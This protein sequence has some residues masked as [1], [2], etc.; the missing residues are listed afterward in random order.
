MEV[1]KTKGTRLFGG[2]VFLLSIVFLMVA[3]Q[4]ASGQV[5]RQKSYNNTF[6]KE[7]VSRYPDYGIE[8]KH[9]NENIYLSF[10]SDSIDNRAISPAIYAYMPKDINMKGVDLIIHFDGGI[11]A[12]F[13]QK[14]HDSENYVEFSVNQETYPILKNNAFKYIEFKGLGKYP[15]YADSNY[16]TSFIK[17]IKG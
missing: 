10:R 15:N 1:V 4:F 9:V 7:V 2:I 3:C 5:L 12:T 14:F 6:D 11:V 16:F 8:L 13:K 17:A